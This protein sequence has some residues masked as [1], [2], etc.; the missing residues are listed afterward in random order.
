MKG[1]ETWMKEGETWM[2]EGETWMKEGETWMKEGETWIKEGDDLKLLYVSM[3]AIRF[4]IGRRGNW[5]LK[6]AWQ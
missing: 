2:K 3:K 4:E 5:D 1:G 6:Y